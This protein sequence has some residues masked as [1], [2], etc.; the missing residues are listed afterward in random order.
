MEKNKAGYMG[1]LGTKKWKGKYYNYIS[2]LKNERNNI[3]LR[4]KYSKF[5]QIENAAKILV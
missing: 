3:K 5:S 4:S 1:M 2:S